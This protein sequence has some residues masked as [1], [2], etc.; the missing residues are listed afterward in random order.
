MPPR[1]PVSTAYRRG[2]TAPAAPRSLPASSAPSQRTNFL[3]GDLFGLRTTLSRYGVSL[4]IQETS[5]VLGN[6]TGGAR[7][8]SRL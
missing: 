6:V 5:E 3:L 2:I 7:K 1:P 4:A 8:G